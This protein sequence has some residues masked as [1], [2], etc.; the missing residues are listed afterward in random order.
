MVS[1]PN[2][3]WLGD[4]TYIRTEEGWLYLAADQRQLLW[5]VADDNYF[6]RSG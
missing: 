6:G 4:I 3:V 2:R 1:A 5:P